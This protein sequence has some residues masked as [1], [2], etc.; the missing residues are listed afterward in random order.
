MKKLSEHDVIFKRIEKRFDNADMK[1]DQIDK[2]FEQVDK[3]FEQ[4][5]K[6]F[7]QVDKHFEQLEEKFDNYH[8]ENME[9]FDNILGILTRL[10]QERYFTVERVNRLEIDLEAH[11]KEIKNIKKV[12]KIA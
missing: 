1:F 5:D 7:E 10:D 2:R 11:G 4:V 12:L 8:N 6:R 3:K 9:R